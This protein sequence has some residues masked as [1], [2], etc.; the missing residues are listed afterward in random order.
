MPSPLR[1]VTLAAT[2]FRAIPPIAAPPQPRR[3]RPQPPASHGNRLP[4]ARPRRRSMAQKA[5]R[6]PRPGRELETPA[7][8]NRQRIAPR[9]RLRPNPRPRSARTPPNPTLP[10]KNVPNLLHRPVIH[11]ERNLPR[12]QRNLHHTAA[13][14]AMPP[15]DQQPYLRPIRGDRI[16]R[17]PPTAQR[18]RPLRVQCRHP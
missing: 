14:G 17:R 8:R 16:R 7:H 1:S 9:H 4:I 5:Q 18:R 12:R 2:G 6:P 10:L 13:P 3:P 15:I 11:R